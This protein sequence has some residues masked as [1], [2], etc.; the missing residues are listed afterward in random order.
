MSQASEVLVSVRA[1]LGDFLTQESRL[2]AISNLDMVSKAS[3]DHS[4]VSSTSPR[5][6]PTRSDKSVIDMDIEEAVSGSSG[7]S[8]NSSRNSAGREKESFLYGQSGFRKGMLELIRMSDVNYIVIFNGEKAGN[9]SKDL[10]S[11][12][13]S[14]DVPL[15]A[16]SDLDDVRF[17]DQW[18]SLVFLDAGL[19]INVINK[20]EFDILKTARDECVTISKLTLRLSN[21]ARDAFFAGYHS[22][23]YRVRK[24]DNPTTEEIV[25]SNKA[26]Y[27]FT[28]QHEIFSK[29]RSLFQT[30][31]NKSMG[32]VDATE[33]GVIPKGRGGARRGRSKAGVVHRG[34]TSTSTESPSVSYLYGTIKCVYC[35][36]EKRMP[37]FNNTEFVV[38]PYCSMTHDKEIITMCMPCATNW[39]NYRTNLKSTM[40]LVLPGEFNEELC[41]LCSDTPD[42]LLLCSFC[43]RSYCKACLAHTL[44]PHM[45]EQLETEKDADWACHACA[46]GVGAKGATPKSKWKSVTLLP[47][48]SGAGEYPALPPPMIPQ[49]SVKTNLDR[50]DRL[51]NGSVELP[52]KKKGGTPPRGPEAPLKVAKNMSEERY[53]AQY[54][55]YVDSIYDNAAK[56]CLFKSD[57]MFHT[58]DACFLCKDGGDLIECDWKRSFGSKRGSCRCRKVYHEYCLAYAVPDGKTWICPRHYCDGCASQSLAYMCK[59][60]PISVCSTCLPSL[61]KT[62]GNNEYASLPTPPYGWEDSSNIQVIVCYTCL[63]MFDKC[64]ASCSDI[65]SQAHPVYSAPRHRVAEDIDIDDGD[66]DGTMFNKSAAPISMPA[67]VNRSGGGRGLGMVRKKEEVLDYLKRPWSKRHRGDSSS[68]GKG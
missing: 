63:R 17:I 24:E 55:L 54:V 26:V 16:S 57:D 6:D 40:G 4:R 8:S 66:L 11:N 58:D 5:G 47:T 56:K 28:N 60:C 7:S 2:R 14:L 61:A 10:L 35:E 68:Q 38:H 31:S 20:I 9:D 46:N 21:A 67:R 45:L 1:S 32:L 41:A 13:I 49:G 19:M 3:F 12:E 27:D 25:R 29:V 50:S 36:A 23:L 51:T 62:Y 18:N 39:D 22:T 59:Y 52:P 64:L 53:F 42:Q 48:D 43:P 30:V 33:D 37:A 15:L 65:L 34:K 44:K